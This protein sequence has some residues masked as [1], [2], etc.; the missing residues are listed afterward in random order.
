VSASEKLRELHPLLTGPPARQFRDRAWDEIVAVVEAAER[1]D[2]DLETNTASGS[3]NYLI[4][5]IVALEQA[6]DRE[7]AT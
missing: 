4:D 7:V 5:A 3:P 1:L 2:A 6:L